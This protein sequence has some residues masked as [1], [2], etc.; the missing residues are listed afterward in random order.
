MRTLLKFIRKL[1]LPTCSFC[2][3]PVEVETGKTD[4]NGKAVHEDSSEK[5]P[6]RCETAGRLKNSRDCAELYR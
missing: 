1:R 5:S 4:D 3:E 6:A 2:N